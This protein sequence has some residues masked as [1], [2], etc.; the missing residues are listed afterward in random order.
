[1]KHN[2]TASSRKH[3]LASLWSKLSSLWSGLVLQWV[4][5]AC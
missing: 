3:L 2:F 4:G 5:K 1:M